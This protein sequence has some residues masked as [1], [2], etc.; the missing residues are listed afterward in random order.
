MK[1]NRK[2]Y[3]PCADLIARNVFGEWLAGERK[4]PGFRKPVDA[5]TFGGVI[6]KGFQECHKNQASAVCD[7]C[8]LDRCFPSWSLFTLNYSHLDWLKSSAIANG[9][10]LMRV[11]SLNSALE[12]NDGKLQTDHSPLFFREIVDVDR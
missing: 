11:V 9:K 7:S 1:W 6:E 3:A 12:C 5:S 8:P 10:E 2:N 4:L